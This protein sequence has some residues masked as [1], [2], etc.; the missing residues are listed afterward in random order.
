MDNDTQLSVLENENENENNNG[1]V[2]EQD[3]SRGLLVAGAI[4]ALQA[5]LRIRAPA[6]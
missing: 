1:A 5:G 2:V 6:R 3:R 4:A